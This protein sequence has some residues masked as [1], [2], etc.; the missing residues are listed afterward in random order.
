MRRLLCLS[1]L[2]GFALANS[3]SFVVLGDRTGIAND[4]VF[5]RVLEEIR[6]LRP[7]F[8]VGIGD[9]IEGYTDD[10]V[11]AAAEWDAVLAMLD[12]TGVPGYFAPGNH[13]IWSP[14]SES[15]FVRRVNPATWSLAHRNSIFIFCDNTRWQRFADWPAEQRRRFR[16][17]LKKARRYQHRFVLMHRPWWRYALER[18]E[19]DTLHEWCR[20]AGI[21]HVFTG[22]DHFYSSHIRDS[23]SYFQVGPS[24][25]RLKVHY[26]R[27]RGGFQNY[28]FGQVI[29]RH[30]SLAVVE[31]GRL[32]PAE[33]VTVGAVAELTRAADSAVALEPVPVMPGRPVDARRRL[34]VTDI[35]DLGQRGTLAWRAEGTA[36][37]VTP[38]SLGFLL[39]PGG[40]GEYDLRVELADPAR[41]WPPPR[42]ALPW[43]HSGD[44]RTELEIP[45][46]VARRA[47][48]TA[49]ASPD[50][51]DAG[52]AAALPLAAFAGDD[53][54]PG[55]VEPVEVRVGFDS[56]NIHL[57]A[58]C[59]ES[60][61]DLITAE[62]TGRDESV[63]SDD[64]LNFVLDPDPAATREW[65]AR[66]AATGDSSLTSPWYYQLFVNPLGT[67]ADRRCRLVGSRSERSWS[68][69]GNWTVT[70][71]RSEDG[72]WTVTVSCPLA[73][74]GDRGGDWGIN[75]TRYQSRLRATAT[76]QPPFR[77]DPR[78]FGTLER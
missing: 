37:R 78:T 46:P 75:C 59:R 32:H 31:P 18:G 42:L 34:A 67:V 10:I 26:D 11:A 5:S 14:A 74:L 64:H 6:L 17:E 12:R 28:L 71:D 69:N 65:A 72:W 60:R 19:P 68:W 7:D 70:A 54:L 3:F 9:L 36:W 57:V 62:V 15:L 43:N 21:T 50:P 76:W 23:I 2:A 8:V 61:P 45:L 29:G 24:G 53:Y 51:A 52:W 77:H 33:F 39:P 4:S 73:E 1:A 56:L 38:E 20:E 35:T 25:S 22:H 55:R 13:D 44:R 47:R 58:R 48:A 40:R 30:V 63:Y 16:A 66:F 49:P 41:P 27:A